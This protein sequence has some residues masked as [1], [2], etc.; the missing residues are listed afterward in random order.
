[1]WAIVVF[2]LFGLAMALSPLYV[3]VKIHVRSHRQPVIKITETREG[4]I[5]EDKEV[6]YY[7]K[8]R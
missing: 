7:H 3:Q 2:F 4:T 1:M 6:I 8:G 5:I